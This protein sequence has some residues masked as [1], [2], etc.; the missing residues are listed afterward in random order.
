VVCDVDF[1]DVFKAL[2]EAWEGEALLIEA[3]SGRAVVGELFASEAK[4]RGLAGIVIYGLVRDVVTLRRMDL[5]VFARGT[6][7]QA[8]TT[9]VARAAV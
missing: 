1:L 7:P 9:Q 3:E 2:S 8:G 5:P 4:R 6:T